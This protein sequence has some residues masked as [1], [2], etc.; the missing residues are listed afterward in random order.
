MHRSNVF[1][2]YG[3]FNKFLAG[4]FFIGARGRG[5]GRS[6]GRF[7]GELTPL[8]YQAS[9]QHSKSE[10]RYCELHHLLS[11]CLDKFQMQIARPWTNFLEEKKHIQ[12]FWLQP[13]V[14]LF[15][16]S[17]ILC[18]I[19]PYGIDLVLRLIIIL[20]HKKSLN[21]IPGLRNPSARKHWQGHWNCIILD[22][23]MHRLVWGVENIYNIAWN[24]LLYF[25]VI[26]YLLIRI[27]LVFTCS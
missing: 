9:T 3:K 12:K 13:F 20:L 26:L 25:N 5:K 14:P 1:H 4:A 10:K 11:M 21:F 19:I 15:V 6:V 18:I 8:H 22:M 24:T 23:L 7:V 2:W 17:I 16:L 27:M